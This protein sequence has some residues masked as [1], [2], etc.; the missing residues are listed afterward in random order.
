MT[1][2]LKFKTLVLGGGPA[3]IYAGK[4]LNEASTDFG[5]IEAQAS[6]GGRINGIKGGS[7]IHTPKDID[8]NRRT[9]EELKK[10]NYYIEEL[11]NLARKSGLEIFEEKEEVIF[12]YNG[13]RINPNITHNIEGITEKLIDRHSGKD[14]DIFSLFDKL[15][16]EQEIE[17]YNKLIKEYPFFYEVIRN[18]LG[19]PES[20]IR[21]SELS[22]VDY[23]NTLSRTSGLIINPN[24]QVLFQEMAK[25]FK[26]KIFLSN[27]VVE[28]NWDKNKV[29]VTTLDKITGNNNYFEA[30]NLIITI[31]PNVLNTKENGEYKIKFN[32]SDDKREAIENQKSST[33]NKGIFY[34]DE[35]FFK[36]N[37]IEANS[38]IHVINDKFENT[39]FFFAK[40]G[41]KPIIM[42]LFGGPKSPEL[43]K[44]QIRGRG[45]E[46]C[47]EEF[48]KKALRNAFGYEFDRYVQDFEF[49]KWNSF[50]YSLGS[51]SGASPGKSDW[52]NILAKPID[53]KIQFAGEWM[54]SVL[55]THIT[56]AMESADIAVKNILENEKTIYRR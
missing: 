4:K 30:D 46:E 53:P 36:D 3:G 49:T 24:L 28:I 6:L 52:R 12:F 43:E 42:S 10:I 20:G 17:N 7:W 29:Y 38:H 51:Y 21:P 18:T 33:L 11:V 56:G 25:P 8:F 13:R 50:E 26:D 39:F 44:M 41:N 32:L 16:S 48:F 23:R 40:P 22:V 55:Q 19:G 15:E 2:Q 35:A 27:E 34:L 5:I 37:N 54:P 1:N 31:P 14:T 9:S 47:V 45:G